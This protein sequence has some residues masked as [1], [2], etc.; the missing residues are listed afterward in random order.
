M[1]LKALVKLLDVF[2][3]ISK[4]KK[5]GIWRFC[6]GFQG[7]LNGFGLPEKDY[8]DLGKDFVGSV[9]DFEA[10]AKSLNERYR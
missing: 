10:V 4:V 3:L 6:K 1:V 5:T 9:R 2:M 8:K 7:L